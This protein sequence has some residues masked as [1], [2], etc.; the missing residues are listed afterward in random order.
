MS[1]SAL[2]LHGRDFCVIDT[3][4]LFVGTTLE[5]ELLLLGSGDEALGR[6]RSECAP[7]GLH[8]EPGRKLASY[9]GGEQA[10]ICCLL[11][12]TLLPATPQRILLVHVLETLSPRNREKLLRRFAETLPR[13]ALFTLTFDGPKPLDAHA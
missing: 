6:V 12:M 9:S 3:S 4:N 5:D 8:P 2:A 1:P 13:A 11:L 10:I 7:F